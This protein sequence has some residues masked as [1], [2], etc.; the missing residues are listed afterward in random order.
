MISRSEARALWEQQW[1][2]H[3]CEKLAKECGVRACA[4]KRKAKEHEEMA[5]DWAADAAEAFKHAAECTDEARA[6]APLTSE[7]MG[8]LFAYSEG[9]AETPDLPA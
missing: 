3:E 9:R 2:R 1:R 4:A 5:R 7:Q 6:I 8:Q